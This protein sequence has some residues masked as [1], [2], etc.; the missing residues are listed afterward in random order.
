[1]RTFLFLLLA[2]ATIDISAAAPWNP[3]RLIDR[4]SVFDT[5]ARRTKEQSRYKKG[6]VCYVRRDCYIF[7]S[8]GYA[9]RYARALNPGERPTII[10]SRLS[11]VGGGGGV[12]MDV[13]WKDDVVEDAKRDAVHTEK[14]TKIKVQGTSGKVVHF[15]KRKKDYYIAE[16]DLMYAREWEHLNNLKT[17]L[18]ATV[19]KAKVKNQTC[20]CYTDLMVQEYRQL[21]AV[22]QNAAQA[23]RQDNRGLITHL[24]PGADVIVMEIYAQKKI[25]KI[26]TMNGKTWYCNLDDLVKAK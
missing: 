3:P 5:P 8:K 20:A 7:T 22:D 11:G 2:A 17:G 19:G 23:W 26:A 10:H 21:A 24:Q 25:A 9:E 14:G 13:E 1:M 6:D 12:G 15:R 18:P 16:S 4:S